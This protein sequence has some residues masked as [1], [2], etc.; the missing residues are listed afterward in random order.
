[1]DKKMCPICS[2]GR[3]LDKDGP[4]ETSYV[5]RKGEERSLILPNIQRRRCE[6]CNEEILDDTATREIEAA[7]RS[8]MGLL[9]ATEIRDLRLRLGKSQLQ[10]S[11]LLGIGEKTYCR[12]ESGSFIQS[13]AFDNY[14]RVIR[15]VPEAALMLNDIEQYGVRAI[16]YPNKEEASEFI[17]LTDVEN[18]SESAENFTEQ[19]ITGNL[20]ACSV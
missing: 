19:L 15:H 8:A 10:M 20:H 5:D 13:V 16:L 17:F 3:L 18:L 6:N 1:M 12:W 14:L 2:K 9:S 7:R 11:R 4:F